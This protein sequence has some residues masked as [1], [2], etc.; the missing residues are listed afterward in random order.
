VP[1]GPDGR[2]MMNMS[3]AMGRAAAAADE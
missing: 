1:L 3:M 2:P